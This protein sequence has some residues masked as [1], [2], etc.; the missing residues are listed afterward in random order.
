MVKRIVLLTVLFIFIA[1][2]AYATI[3]NIAGFEIIQITNCT[4]SGTMSVGT[5]ATFYS[6]T[7]KL[8]PDHD[9][10]LA[11]LF[12]SSGSVSVTLS[13][14]QG[15]EAPTTEGDV[16]TAKYDVPVGSSAIETCTV[17]TMRIATLSPKVTPYARIKAVGG[18]GNHSSTTFTAYLIIAEN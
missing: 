5:S 12:V 6:N 3:E 15:L 16:E 9:M 8:H 17:E 1:L 18:A 2:P 4:L 11:Y 10:S 13:L 7:F 14:E